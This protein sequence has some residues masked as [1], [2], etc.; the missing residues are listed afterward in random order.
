LESA[1]ANVLKEAGLSAEQLSQVSKG[2]EITADAMK[3]GKIGGGM[4]DASLKAADIDPSFYH[5]AMDT[6][7]KAGL[8]ETDLTSGDLVTRGASLLGRKFGLTAE[9][10]QNVAKGLQTLMSA[11]FTG[12]A[13]QTAVEMSPRVLDA[14]KDGDYD[15]AAEYATEAA[16]S[17]LFAVAGATHAL[18]SAGELVDPSLGTKLRPTDEAM[19]AK[20]QFDVRDADEQQANE[21]G[22]LLQ[23]AALKTLGHKAPEDHPLLS[24]ATIDSQKEQLAKIYH[25]AALGGDTEAARQ[26]FNAVAEAAGREERL[27]ESPDNGQPATDIRRVYHWSPQDLTETDPAKAGTGI[28]GAERDRPQVKGTYFGEEAYKEPAVQNRGNA[29]KYYA[30]IDYNKVYD[31]EKDPLGLK[32][33]AAEVAYKTG[34]GSGYEFEKLVQDNG[35]EGYRSPQQGVVKYFEKVP[36]K[37]FTEDT[38]PLAPR[39][40]SGQPVQHPTLPSNLQE[41]I[42]N[43][44]LKNKPAAYIDGLLNSYKGVYDGLSPDELSVAT[45]L[46][47]KLNKSWEDAA[48]NDLMT[49]R[50]E[51]YMRRIWKKPSPEMNMLIR[52]AQNGKFAT[53]VSMAKHRTFTDE[54][55]PILK[56]Y[57]LATE[58]PVRLSSQYLADTYTVIANRNLE[59]RLLDTAVRASDGRPAAVLMGMGKAVTDEQPA[60]LITPSRV[61]NIAIDDKEIARLAGSGDLQRHLDSGAIVDVTPR[62]HQWDIQKGID[63]LES[64]MVS[65][66]IKYDLEGN[67]LSLRDVNLLKAVRDGKQPMSDLDA[68]NAGQKPVYIWRPQDYITINHPSLRNWNFLTNDPDGNPVIAK[69]DLAIHPEYAKY[70]ERRLGLEKSGLQEWAPTRALL[71]GGAMAKKTL[72]ALSPFHMNQE[73]LRAV[74]TGINPLMKSAPTIEES[75]QLRLGVENGLGVEPDYKGIQEHSEGLTGGSALIGKIPGVGSTLAKSL[76]WYQHFLFQKYIPNLKVR[77]YLKM[78]DQY[79]DAHSD[80]TDQ[81]VA[82]IAAQ[83]TNDTFGG[84]NWK[85]MGR[86]AATQDWSRLMLLAPDW[87]ESEMRSV[88]RL[89]NRDDGSI[90]RAQILKM[91]MG[92]WGVARVLNMVS[93]GNPHLEAPFSLAVKND[94]G[95]ETLYSMR[96]LPTDMLHMATDPVGFLKGRLSPAVRAG[97]EIYTG[98]DQFGRKLAPGDM[99]VDLFRNLAP[100]PVQSLGQVVSGTS[101]ETGNIGQVVKAVGGTAASYRTEAQKLA[102]NLA[103][104]HSEDGVLDS[105][106]LQRHRV[107][108]QFE[109]N[110][111]QGTMTMPQLNGLVINGQLPQADAKKITENLRV[112]QKLTPDQASLYTRASRLPAKELLDVYDLSTDTE[113]QALIPLVLK[114]RRTYT[115]RAMSDETPVERMRDPVL[116][117]LSSIRTDQPLF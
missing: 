2:A 19:D 71:K 4:L 67:S 60:T 112:T 84:Q 78:F 25:W 6:L 72:L 22:R 69:S 37:P 91:S 66:P 111:R 76:D 95:K 48:A 99:A 12:M 101:P 80:W 10:S 92:M 98:R 26:S 116:R 57:E 47:D 65:A 51:N 96:T 54:L 38:A 83:H 36:V 1:G 109:D 11:G 113:K 74:M 29:K 75:P 82:E 77:G 58:D 42:A 106:Q 114:A 23:E 28:R 97:Q 52:D 40:L 16:A 24:Q 59:S 39:P 86:S 88:A 117:R 107:L 34:T 44:D 33:K 103:S 68:Y 94:E 100:I 64:K 53:D 5:G 50:V 89:F 110:L 49:N 85:A 31:L 81:K 32:Q 8:K 90:G 61:R 9:K 41:L 30:D 105:T 104:N 14:L 15:H 79:K 73:A 102:A 108:M 43:S 63:R 18:H 35:F 45:T 115:K 17:G 70:F 46:R 3:T 87:L 55:T 7:Y 93:T 27:R 56:G 62:V 20:R 21:R 13:A